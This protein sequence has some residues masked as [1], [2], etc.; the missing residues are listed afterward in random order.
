MNAREVQVPYSFCSVELCG[1]L[2]KKFIDY[3]DKSLGEELID[4][5]KQNIFK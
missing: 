5:Y 1:P 2:Y 4:Y 3:L